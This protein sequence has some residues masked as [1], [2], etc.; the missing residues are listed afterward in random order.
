MR[1]VFTALSS[2]VRREILALLRERALTAG[3]IADRIPLAK[4]TLS[5]HFN[6][7]KQ[8]GLVSADRQG[9][10]ITYRINTSVVEDALAALLRLTRKETE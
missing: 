4:P 3:E 2:P 9:S 8:A 5:G 10:T 6:V 1:D 7:L